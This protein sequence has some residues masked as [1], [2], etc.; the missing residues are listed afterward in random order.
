MYIA[1]RFYQINIADNLTIIAVSK[2]RPKQSIRF[3]YLQKN[4][5]MIPKNRYRANVI[6]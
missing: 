6:F 2:D 5:A 3:E 1:L 4:F